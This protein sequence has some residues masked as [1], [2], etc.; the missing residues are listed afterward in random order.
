MK[1]EAEQQR[2]KEEEAERLRIKQERL[3]TERPQRLKLRNAVELAFIE[4]AADVA[5]FFNHSH[6][7][8]LLQDQ[9]GDDVPLADVERAAA[10]FRNLLLKFAAKQRLREFFEEHADEIQ[11]HYSWHRFHSF[12]E[13]NLSIDLVLE[14]VLTAET[15]MR[16]MLQKLIDKQA[17]Q[18]VA[19][20]VKQTARQIEQ[21]TEGI[22]VIASA[23]GEI[24]TFDPLKKQA[25]LAMTLS[26]ADIK[27]RAVVE[28]LVKKELPSD[29][30]DL[31]RQQ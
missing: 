9:L 13:A 26:S 11:A 17:Q 2:I 7:E 28:E 19:V 22:A 21:Q 5:R 31:I 8:V 12:V 10:G 23:V 20:G 29:G 4:H 6:L 27:T 14:D 16:E 18:R 3:S 25:I 15:Q 30:T 1:F 24:E